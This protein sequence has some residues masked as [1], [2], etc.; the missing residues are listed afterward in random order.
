MVAKPKAVNIALMTLIC[1][2][3]GG[4][5]YWAET[6]N[7]ANKTLRSLG[8]KNERGHM[9]GFDAGRSLLNR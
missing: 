2:G 3:L 6:G 5:N 7:G 9:S 1:I 8:L 4:I